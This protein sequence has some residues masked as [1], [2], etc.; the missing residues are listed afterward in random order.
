MQ[1]PAFEFMYM[2]SLLLPQQD[3]GT[4]LMMA[5]QS[6]HTSVVKLLLQAKAKPDMQ[7]KVAITVV[8]CLV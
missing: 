5:S 8:A 7:S 4:P 1:I 6:G 3:G 2:C